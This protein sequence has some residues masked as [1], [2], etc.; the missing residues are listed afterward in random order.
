MKVVLY[1]LDIGVLPIYIETWAYPALVVGELETVLEI[2]EGV[3]VLVPCPP[4]TPKSLRAMAEL[5]ER[6]EAAGKTKAVL[7]VSTQCDG[8]GLVAV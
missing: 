8:I 7:V 4:V 6:A 3:K 2:R 1:I 5:L